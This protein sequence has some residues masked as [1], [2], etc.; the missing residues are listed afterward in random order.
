MKLCLFSVNGVF[1]YSEQIGVILDDVVIDVAATYRSYLRENKI[2]D[3]NRVE[4]VA[5]MYIPKDMTAFI[6]GGELSMKAV[7]EAVEFARQHATSTW[8]KHTYPFDNVKLHPPIKK[9]PTVRDFLSFELHYKN[10]LGGEVPE[11]WYERPIYY[12]TVASTIIGP[13]EICYWPSYSKVMDY[14]L[15]IACILGKRGVNLSPKEA[16]K[17]IFGYMIYNDFSARDTQ[18]REMEGRLGPAKGKDFCTSMGPYIVTADEIE[19]VYNLKMTAKVNGELWSEGN[20]STMYRTF[21][22]IISY[23][24]QGEP[25]VPGD[26]FGSGTVGNGCG[27]ELGKFLNDGDIVELEIEQ[28]GVLRNQIK[29]TKEV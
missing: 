11:V 28:L 13:E 12:K 4:E 8:E 21:A 15:E 5:A 20:T 16:E 3:I 27:L 1:P 25:V 29:V 6:E 18:L 22:D 24:S 26:I 10:S 14:E 17:H 7:D 23:V 9:P 19:N 2:V